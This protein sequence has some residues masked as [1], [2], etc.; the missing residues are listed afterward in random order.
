[1]NDAASASVIVR[2][3][4]FA[5]PSKPGQKILN[6]VSFQVKKSEIV[7]LAGPNGC[8]KTTLINLIAGFL[9]PDKGEI[10]LNSNNGFASVVFQ[11]L[12]LLD[13]KNAQENIELAL[14]PKK[15]SKEERSKA[16]HD[17]L[18][19]CRIE[20][21]KSKLPKELSGG[22]KQRVAIARAIAPRPALLLLDEP[23]SS[24]DRQTRI[25]LQKDLFKIAHATETSVILVTHHLGEVM[26]YANQVLFLNNGRIT[27]KKR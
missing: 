24:L 4:S 17:C 27:S 20:A 9:K 19:L 10:R 6:N 25:L 8:G 12:G 11:Q 1:M 21:E 2:N 22:M 7:C 23:F 3:V 18:K 15:M 26:R 13:W 16:V 14:L 5:Y